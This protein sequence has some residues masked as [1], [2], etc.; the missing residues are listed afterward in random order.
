M[1]RADK[2]PERMEFSEWLPRPKDAKPVEFEIVSG[3]RLHDENYGVDRRGKGWLRFD[4][5][6]LR[7][8]DDSEE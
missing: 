3:P 1:Y 5:L 7:I 6:D 2:D 8:K 4:Y